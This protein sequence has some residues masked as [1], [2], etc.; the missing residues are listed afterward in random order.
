MFVRDSLLVHK[1]IGLVVYKVAHGY[2]ATFTTDRFCVGAST[3]RNYMDIIVDVLSDEQ[4]P[5][6]RYI[7]IQWGQRL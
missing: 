4:K 2:S 7:S 3:I 1:A 6:A 5:F